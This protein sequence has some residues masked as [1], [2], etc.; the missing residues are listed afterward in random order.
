[1][2]RSYFPSRS[3]VN[4]SHLGSALSDLLSAGFAGITHDPATWPQG[5]TI[6]T[7][8]RAIA[9]AEGADQ[10]STAPDR[11][12]NPGDLSRGDEHGQNVSEY[13]TLP[14]G[15]VEMVFAS[16]QDGWQALY[17]K[18]ANIAAGLSATYSPRMTWLDVGRKWAGNS[19]VWSA[20]VARELGVSPAATFGETLAMLSQNNSWALPAV[21]APLASAS[22]SVN[23]SPSPVGLL[24]AVAGVSVALSF[25]ID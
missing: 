10:A 20:N 19:A 25:L 17:S 12:N 4:A 3:T 6:W 22:S 2:S 23:G 14:D 21:P 15:E 7:I 9:R 8:A 16:K 24:L 5:D 1:M 18:L 13:Q 11:Y